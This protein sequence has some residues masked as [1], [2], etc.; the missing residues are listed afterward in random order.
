MQMRLDLSMS[1]T[2]KRMSRLLLK[3]QAIFKSAGQMWQY[4]FDKHFAL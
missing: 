3:G 1:Q 4:T 2:V